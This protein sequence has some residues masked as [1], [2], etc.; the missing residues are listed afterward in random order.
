MLGSIILAL[1][2]LGAG[3]LAAPV[4][5]N[6]DVAAGTPGGMDA[7]SEYFNL[8]ASKVQQSRTMAVAPVCDMAH[9]VIALGGA[10]GSL[11]APSAGLTLKHV[12][13]GRGTQ[14]Y[15]CDTSAPRAAPIATGALATL[16]NASCVAATDP[17][18]LD[19]LPRVAL[20][21]DLSSGG[22]GPAAAAGPPLPPSD[23]AISGHHYFA[24]ATT[25]FFDLD[26]A[27][28]RLGTAPC[29]KNNSMAAPP[30][31][32][33]GRH[34]EPAVAWLKL[35]ARPG[36]TGRLQEVYRVNTAG[37]SP[38]ATCAGMPPA[39]EVQYSAQYWF[40]QD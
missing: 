25:P 36:A 16:F 30:G 17:D 7:L 12:A 10:A 14:N 28:L 26:A 29:L 32:P 2:A 13:I 15:T 35:L 8:L 38:P 18:L 3:A 37:G 33:P 24:S 31:A 27:G 39:F 23:L 21:F 22:P 9:A 19:L 1:A 40:Y 4:T 11:P 6:L 34:A 20:Q 5:P